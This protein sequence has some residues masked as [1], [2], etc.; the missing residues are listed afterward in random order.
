MKKI[1]ALSIFVLMLMTSCS[2]KPQT[3]P[4]AS[5]SQPFEQQASSTESTPSSESKKSVLTLGS[6]LV[7]DGFDVTIGNTVNWATVE[8]EFSD[9]HGKDVIAVPVTIKNNNDE[10]TSF[11]QFNYLFFGA[12][13]T[14]LRDITSYFDNDLSTIG[15]MRPG[16]EASGFFHMLYDGD[17]T[18]YIAFDDYKEKVEVEIPI[19]K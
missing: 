17:A 1:F 7:C 11:N 18:Y 10:T 6:S 19:Q 5:S 12:E 16:A 13:G 8:N 2:G 4:D 15:Q 14:Q 9:H 3:T